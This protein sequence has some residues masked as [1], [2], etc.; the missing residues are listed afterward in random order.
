MSIR[1][2]PNRWLPVSIGVAIVV[3]IIVRG[4]SWRPIGLPEK[5]LHWGDEYRL[6]ERIS[7]GDITPEERLRLIADLDALPVGTYALHHRW[8]LI[9]NVNPFESWDA[10]GFHPE[11]SRWPRDV[12]LLWATSY[13]KADIENGGFHQFFGNGT[14]TFAPEMQECLERMGLHESADLVK[15][16]MLVFGQPYPRSQEARRQFLERIPGN[17]REEYDPFQALDEPFY[18]SLKAG[19]LSFGA[20]ADKWLR[21]QCGIQRL[22]DEVRADE[23]SSKPEPRALDRAIIV[24]DPGHGGQ[25]YS[26]SYT[27]G[28]RGV[29]S[30]LTESELNLRVAVEL[31]RFLKEQGA[32]VYLT[33]TGDH[34]LS[35]EGSTSRAEL[36][37]RI[38]FFEHHGA[39]FFLSVHHNAGRPGAGHT[40]L[41]KHNVADDTLYEALGRMVNDALEGA[42]PGPKLP[43]IKGSYH[44]LRE[45]VIPGTI[46]E[47]GFMTNRE[48]D[49]LSTRPD[50]PNKEA[51]ALRNGAIKYWAEHKDALIALRQRLMKERAEHP[52][53]PKTLTAIELNPEFRRRM[54]TL[55]ATVDPG[56]KY[57]PAKI[58][59]YLESFKKTVVTDPKATFTVKGEYDGRVIRLT[60]ATSDRKYHDRLIDML[61]AMKLYNIANDIQFR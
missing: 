24:V 47:S 11:R 35:A 38:D 60:G 58:G 8:L 21:E 10:Q 40:A 19:G 48:F 14:G 54:E 56:A 36:H 29:V 5:A 25:R 7:S 16:A 18:A 26:R 43:L 17:R 9:N 1:L 15:R 23:A 3:F 37:A 27:G 28:T 46:A 61:V 50:Y 12:Q 4:S 33:R 59:A 41:Y 13:G 52:R 55:L 6:I 45:T 51:T 57:D 2:D 22:S 34:R 49:E 53:D 39:H 31:A 32:T 42:V 30:G 20:R 44:I